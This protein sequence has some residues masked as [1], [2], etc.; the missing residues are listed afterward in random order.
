MR[1]CTDDR[2]QKKQGLFWKDVKEEREKNSGR[3]VRM[4]FMN[5]EVNKFIE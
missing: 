5:K 3:S 2:F 4:K 1:K